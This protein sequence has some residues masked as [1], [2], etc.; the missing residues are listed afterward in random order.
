MTFARATADMLAEISV[1]VT[2][3]QPSVNV[4]NNEDKL[5]CFVTEIPNAHQQNSKRHFVLKNILYFSFITFI[6]SG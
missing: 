1:F 6:T 3:V 4:G 2:T 5:I